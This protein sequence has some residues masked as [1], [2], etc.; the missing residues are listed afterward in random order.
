MWINKPFFKYAAGTIFVLIIIFLLGKIDYFLWPIRALVATIFFP[1]VISGI[2]YYILRPLVRLVSRSLP[3]TASIIVIFAVVLGAGYLGF[4]AIG[5]L[6]G[7]QVTE[8]SENLPA[9]MEDLSDET[10]KVV[11]KNNM[12]MFS[13]DQVKNKALNFLETILS[14]AGENVMKVFST[15]TSIVTVMVV[16]PFILFYF[17]KDDHKLRP[18]LLK[19]LPDK[20]EEEGNKIL[21]D[22]DKTLFSYVTGQFIVAVVDGVL[23]YFGYKIIGLEYALTLAFFAMFLTVVPFLG[24]VLGI[25][26]AIFIGLLQGPGMVLKIILV[27]IAVQLLESNLVSPHVMGKRLNLHPLTVI[28]ILMAAGSIYGFIGILIAIPF[29]SVVKVLVKDFR[30]FYRLRT[31]KSLLSEEI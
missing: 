24:P 29:Y 20:H 21:G 7:S 26:P 25:I 31:R 22:I 5:N 19:Y 8:L 28:I 13:Y 27:L 12:G 23:M 2:L 14:G 9:K 16:V 3:K 30:R 17:L 18:F 4:N 11:E 6:I 1:V 15:I 10:E